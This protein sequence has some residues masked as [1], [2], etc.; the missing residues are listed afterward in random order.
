MFMSYRTFRRIRNWVAF[1]GATLVGYDLLK[2]VAYGGASLEEEVVRF[3]GWLFICV[4][5]GFGGLFPV[6]NRREAVV[7]IRIFREPYS[8]RSVVVEG[9]FTA[10]M[11]Y[12]GWMAWRFDELPRMIGFL[13]LFVIVGMDTVWR[14]R[15][16]R[17]K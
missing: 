5:A 4:I 3:V 10:Y 12:L 15:L 6:G 11:A 9:I 2:Y 8:R 17:Q 1:G 13:L 16:A 7:D 14:W